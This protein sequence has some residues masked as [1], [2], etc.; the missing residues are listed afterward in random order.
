MF[1]RLGLST[2][3]GA[4]ALAASGG[5]PANGSSPLPVLGNVAGSPLTRPSSLSFGGDGNFYL[6]GLRWSSWK[7]TA[8]SAV[9]KAHENDCVPFCAEGH[10]HVYS[11]SV[12][13]SRA[14]LCSNGRVEYTRISYRFLGK[15]PAET[16]PVHRFSAPLGVSPRC[17]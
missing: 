9:G 16:G 4:L 15:R 6:T 3:I 7:M 11:V 5:Y 1:V 14:E 2:V 12:S 13:L 8:A 17:P 10:F